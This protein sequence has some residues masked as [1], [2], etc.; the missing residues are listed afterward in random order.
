[1]ETRL[2]LEAALQ[3]YLDVTVASSADR[4]LRAADGGPFDVLVF[5]ISL[6]RG[7][8]GVA[9][10]QTLRERPAYAETPALAVTAYALSGDAD[11]FRAAGFDAYLSKPF[12]QEDI[13][14]VL[15]GFLGTSFAQMDDV[16]SGVP[17]SGEG[18]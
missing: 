11:R 4:A 1:M 16:A 2:F 12:F 17:R 10:L 13:L 9:L 3:D 7:K 18:A 14:R 15:D 5:D 6:G 8:D